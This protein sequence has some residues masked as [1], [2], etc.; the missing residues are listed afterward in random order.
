MVTPSV[1]QKG[2]KKIR[3]KKVEKN[4]EV[5][6]APVK[7]SVLKSEDRQLTWM[8][9]IIA[10]VIG[11]VFVSYFAVEGSKSFDYGGVAWTVEDYG[12][13]DVYHARFP[14]LT[15]ANLF[16]NLYLR[17][18]PRRNDVPVSGGFKSFK[19]GGYI[20]LS[21][22][23]EACRGEASRVMIDLGAFLKSGLGME[24]IKVATGTVD[25]G[26]SLETGTPYINC[27]NTD[28][29]VFM[30]DVGEARVVQDDVNRFCYRIYVE[31]CDD[32][33]GVEKF[34][35]EIVSAFIE[36]D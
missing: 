17:N 30:V 20:S 36:S 33:L 7:K 2:K 1:P 28:M 32:V 34:M 22:E 16:Y 31:D 24:T 6:E 21:Q 15:G 19:R 5:A 27:S 11:S 3:K 8:F 23:F 29:S 13:F 12:D 35:T 9:V 4:V 25:V 10:V 14:A 26:F 18:D